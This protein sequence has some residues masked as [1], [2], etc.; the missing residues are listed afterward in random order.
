[1]S[2]FVALAC[3]AAAV[4]G[5]AVAQS[6]RPNAAIA[7]AVASDA[8]TPANRERDRYRHPAETLAFFGVKPTDTVVEF[9]PGG[10]WYTEILAPM[11]KGRGNYVALVPMS[12]GDRTRTMLAGKAAQFGA[13]RVETV[14]MAAGTTTMAPGT[15]DV[16]LTFRNVH[17]LTMQDNAAVPANAFKT[18]FAALKP[19]GTLGIVDHR[20]PED[21]DTALEKS[22]GYLKRSTVVRLATAAGFRLAGESPVNANPR[23]THDHPEGVW[24]LPPNYR[25]KDVDRAKYAAIGESDRMTLKFVKPR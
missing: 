11:V 4:T 25:L 15:A 2:R 8:R 9:I 6:T 1:M 18:F 21:K 7:A 17:N 10:G 5:G 13:A 12:Q 3:I 24:T 19:G 22:S 23:D 20:L 14:D 16:V